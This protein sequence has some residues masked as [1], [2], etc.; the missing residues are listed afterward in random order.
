VPEGWSVSFA[1]LIIADDSRPP[2]L[3]TRKSESVEKTRACCRF[4]IANDKKELMQR[5]MAEFYGSYSKEHSCWIRKHDGTNYCM[6]PTHLDI[7]GSDENRKIFIAVGGSKL[8]E[9]GQLEECHAC[10]GALGLIV[11]AEAGS[12]LGVVAKNKLFE[13]IGSWGSA[14][15]PEAFS[16]REIGPKGSNGWLIK[17]AYTQGGKT[18]VTVDIHGVVGDGV[19]PLGSVITDFDNSGDCGERG[20]PHCTNISGD[21]V[22]DANSRADTFYPLILRASGIRKGRAFKGTYRFVFDRHA[23]QYTAPRNMPEE[24]SP[25][26]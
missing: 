18:S 22:I 25:S 16:V 21:L 3:A 15:G 1:S 26:I 19:V 8:D 20:L 17:T 4:A 23:L 7:V 6:N 2:A 12:Q 9:N 11:L 13:E 14:P 24:L 5:V 10:A